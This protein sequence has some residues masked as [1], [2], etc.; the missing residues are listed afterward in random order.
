MLIKTKLQKIKGVINPNKHRIEFERLLRDLGYKD[1]SPLYFCEKETKQINYMCN[2]GAMGIYNTIILYYN[3]KSYL[4]TEFNGN[5]GSPFMKERISALA[6]NIHFNEKTRIGEV[7]WKVVY[8]KQPTE[9]TLEQRKKIFYAFIRD[10]YDHFN[11]GMLG[12]TPRVG[13]VLV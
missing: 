6:E 11:N 2:D 7:S 3:K 13:D 12:I 8:T 5:Y 1:R 9:F 10:S 4:Y